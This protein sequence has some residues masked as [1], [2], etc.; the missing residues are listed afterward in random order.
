M[1]DRLEE[2]NQAFDNIW[3]NTNQLPMLLESW[4][5]MVAEYMQT[6]AANE[7]E[8]AALKI[9]MDRWQKTLYE[10]RS[11]IQAYQ[12]KLKPQILRGEESLAKLT[13][14]ERYQKAK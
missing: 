9:A 1:T 6:L 2:L 10:N 11:I 13:Q 5:E 7:D 4:Q 12:E 3:L 14:S 8:I